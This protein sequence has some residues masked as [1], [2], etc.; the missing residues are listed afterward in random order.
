[1]ESSNVELLAL[2]YRAGTNMSSDTD[3]GRA[4]GFDPASQAAANLIF[5]NTAQLALG[6]LLDGGR[7]GDF[8]RVGLLG[9]FKVQVLNV[10]SQSYPLTVGQSAMFTAA[11][12]GYAAVGKLL[13]KEG[14]E[15]GNTVSGQF[16]MAFMHFG[17][18]PIYGGQVTSL[19]AGITQIPVV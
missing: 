16:A 6:V 5:V 13:G 2:S 15:L 17:A 1:M 3:I 18:Q 10:I 11:G 7:S 19:A 12:S 9:A 8:V 4:V 14:T